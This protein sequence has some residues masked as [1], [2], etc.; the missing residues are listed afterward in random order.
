M[1]NVLSKA[2]FARQL[3]VNRSTITRWAQQGRIV[4]AP[5]GK[6]KVKESIAQLKKTDSGAGKWK[7]DDSKND[8]KS[9]PA[10]DLTLDDDLDVVSG[11]LGEERAYWKAKALDSNNKLVL[12]QQSLEQGERVRLQ[13]LEREMRGLA[14]SLKHGV[15]NLVDNLAPQLAHMPDAA[16]RQQYIDAEVHKLFERVIG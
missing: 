11:E 10:D 6:V 9:A 14:K 4:L 5:N 8:D 13:D 3:E 16:E 1:S 7:Q 15:I 12:L 2:E